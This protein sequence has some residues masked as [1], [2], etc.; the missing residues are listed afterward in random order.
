MIARG[1]KAK[2]AMNI[3]ILLVVAMILINLVIVVTVQRDLIRSET[4]KGKMVLAR[5]EEHALGVALWKDMGSHSDSKA[6]I[7]K[8][9]D[10]A[11]IHCALI[12]GKNHPTA[13]ASFRPS[14]PQFRWLFGHQSPSAWRRRNLW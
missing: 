11:G 4:T 3:V 14:Q 12:M 2:M 1:L 6:K 7:R 8:I 9:L 13:D 10:E 5:L